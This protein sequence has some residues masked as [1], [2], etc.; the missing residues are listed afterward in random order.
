MIYFDN[1]GSTKSDEEILASFLEDEKNNFANPSAKHG[2]GE[3]LGSKL[4][5]IKK[6][7]LKL[8]NLKD[9]EY[10]V[11]FTSGVTE[12]NN[13]FLLGYSR[14]NK[15]KGN[16]IITTKVEH[17]ASLFPCKELEKEGFD[18]HYVGINEELDLDYKE[19]ESFISPNTIL[20]SIMGVNN[21]TGG[22]FDL[23]RINELRKKYP[24][25]VFYTDLAQAVFKEKVDYSQFDAFSFSAYKNYGIKGI[26][27]LVKKKKIKL[28]SLVYGGGQEYGYRSGTQSYPLI[29]SLLNSEVKAK[30]EFEKNYKNIE[31]VSNYLINRL[32]NELSEEIILNLPKQRSPYI[33]NFSLLNKK[34]SVVVEALS[35]EEIYVSTKSAC[36]DKFCEESH[37]ILEY[38]KDA[39]RASNSIR[40]SFSKH[41]TKEEVDEFI[42]TLK[43]IIKQVKGF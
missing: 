40:I 1:A 12:A 5:K 4:D 6:E 31:E 14:A 27:A 36:N 11:I 9:S 29:H 37:V 42:E 16:E 22:V 39:K 24:K 18:L 10:E 34:A 33:V 30:N 35:N 41:S 2:F 15:N 17:K 38:F 19:L 7:L 26:G 20:I 21:E 43:R 13:L 32:K 28:E 8:F 23:K 3:L 25:I